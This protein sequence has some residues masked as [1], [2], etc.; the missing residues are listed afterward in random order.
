MDKA[1]LKLMA[2]ARKERKLFMLLFPAVIKEATKHFLDF[3]DLVVYNEW[4]AK[5]R[6]ENAD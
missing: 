6:E 3:T 5:R 4:I 2:H 1:I